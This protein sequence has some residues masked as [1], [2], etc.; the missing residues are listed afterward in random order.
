VMVNNLLLEFKL[1]FSNWSTA[2][3]SES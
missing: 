3:I 1:H 2:E